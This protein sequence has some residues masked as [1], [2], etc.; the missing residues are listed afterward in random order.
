MTSVTFTFKQYPELG[1]LKRLYDKDNKELLSPLQ[2]VCYGC[3]LVG[4]EA[5]C[6]IDGDC[7]DKEYVV[8][9]GE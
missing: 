9:K 6:T 3:C 4:T 1:K 5:C 7:A 2:S 8:I